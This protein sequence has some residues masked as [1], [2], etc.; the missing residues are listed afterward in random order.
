MRKMG[1]LRKAM[2]IT[3]WTMM[4]STLAIAGIFPFAGFWS[5]DEILL[6]AF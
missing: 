2:P 3:F 6:V 1:G 4:I 5:K